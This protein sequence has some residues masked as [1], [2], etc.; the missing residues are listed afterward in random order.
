MA[1]ALGGLAWHSSGIRLL[2]YL[3]G[4]THGFLV[5]QPTYQFHWYTSSVLAILQP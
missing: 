5:L 2:G 4:T 1:S 3:G